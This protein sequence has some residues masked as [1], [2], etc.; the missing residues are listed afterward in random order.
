[1]NSA[2]EQDE[3]VDENEM[4]A[5]DIARHQHVWGSGVSLGRHPY[6][7][8]AIDPVIHAQSAAEAAE[9]RSRIQAIQ[10]LHSS[11]DKGW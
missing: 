11:G 9:A 1:M 10:H 3:V 5:G 8:H 2:P 6:N 7:P 4:A